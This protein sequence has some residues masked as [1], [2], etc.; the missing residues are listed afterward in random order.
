M[1]ATQILPH[2]WNGH[3]TWTQVPGDCYVVTGRTVYGV[4]FRTE[5]E[6]W[7]H[8]SGINLYSGSVWLLRN[9]RRYLIKRVAP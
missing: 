4:R 6:S 9:G 3:V 5:T 7:L 2:R 1:T 8:A